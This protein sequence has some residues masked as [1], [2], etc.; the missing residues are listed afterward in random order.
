MGL[1]ETTRGLLP[2]AGET[3]IH[4]HTHTHLCVYYID[5]N[6]TFSLYSVSHPRRQIQ[7]HYIGSMVCVGNRSHLTLTLFALQGAVSAS[8][9]WSESL[10]PKNSSSQVLCHLRLWSGWSS[11][12]PSC[13]C[14]NTHSAYG[15]V[16]C[17]VGRSTRRGPDRAG[18]GPGQSGY[19]TEPDGWRRLHRGTQPGS[20]NTAPGTDRQTDRPVVLQYVPFT[21]LDFSQRLVNLT[22]TF[23]LI[24]LSFLVL[25]SVFTSEKRSLSISS[26]RP[27]SFT[28]SLCSLCT[29]TADAK[30]Q[31]KWRYW[32]HTHTH[33][34]FLL[35]PFLR[36]L[37]PSV[38]PKRLWTE[39]LR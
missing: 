35:L 23:Q 39:A 28:I 16:W 1:I 2:G 26:L 17:N 34:L 36:L 21:G 8:P 14:G 10:W 38:W 33:T 11:D 27:L 9:G 4:T 29:W 6:D 15:W 31:F 13:V 25:S 30:W 19:R 12:Q 24:A 3:H 20:G 18:T 22:P 37:L 7:M 32:L 5:N